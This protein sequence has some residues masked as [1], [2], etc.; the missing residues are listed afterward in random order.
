MQRPKLS[1]ELMTP[2]TDDEESEESEE[3]IIEELV[4]DGAFISIK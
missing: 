3:E 1:T 2:D 4:T